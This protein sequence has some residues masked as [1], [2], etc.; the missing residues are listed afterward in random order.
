MPAPRA[1]LS[2]SAAVSPSDQLI[3]WRHR[4]QRGIEKIIGVEAVKLFREGRALIHGDPQPTVRSRVEPRRPEEG[5]LAAKKVDW[6]HA[7]G[8]GVVPDLAIGEAADKL[9]PA[10]NSMG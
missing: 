7:S 3:A 4:Q 2:A 5:Q 6:D 9:Q 1:A 10:G 8:D